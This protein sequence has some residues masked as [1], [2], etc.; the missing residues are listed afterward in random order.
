MVRCYANANFP[1]AVVERLRKLGHDVLTVREAGHDNQQ[2]SDEG[3]LLFAVSEQRAV[4][5]INRRDF[6]RLHHTQP[7]HCGIIVCTEDTDSEGQASRID[8]AMRA[9]GDMSGRLIRIN[10]PTQ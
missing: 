6:V 5:T 8:A 2:I 1:L 3:V 7:Q 9:A 4:I 10:R